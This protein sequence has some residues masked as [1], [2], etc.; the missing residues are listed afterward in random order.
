MRHGAQGCLPG[1]CAACQPEAYLYRSRAVRT[2]EGAATDRIGGADAGADGGRRG[3]PPFSPSDALAKV[4]PRQPAFRRAPRWTEGATLPGSASAATWPGRRLRRPGIIARWRR[5]EVST[6]AGSGSATVLLAVVPCTGAAA[7]SRC[8]DD[9]RRRNRAMTAGATSAV[10]RMVGRD[11]CRCRLL[12]ARL[13]AIPGMTRK[14]CG[15]QIAQP[16]ISAPGAR[17]QRRELRLTGCAGI[18]LCTIG[19]PISDIAPIRMRVSGVTSPDPVTASIITVRIAPQI[20][21]VKLGSMGARVVRLPTTRRTALIRKDNRVAGFGEMRWELDRWELENSSRVGAPQDRA[22]GAGPAGANDCPLGS[23]VAKNAAG[24]V[25]QW[26][27]LAAHNRL[28]AG[29]SP[30]GPTMTELPV[31]ARTS[32]LKE[33]PP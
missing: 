33:G 8:R 7:R 5:P 10:R 6:R 23:L 26:S 16:P 14:R 30:A 32:S 4:R 24:P 21:M 1:I 2:V 12:A 22:D 15:H 25:A 18:M 27:E 19:R 11:R 20:T 13:V 9:D 28:V 31:A 3:V 29:S 17:V